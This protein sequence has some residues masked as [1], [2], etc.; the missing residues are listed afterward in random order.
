MKR[1]RLAF[2]ILLLFLV[3]ATIS[4]TA[5]YSPPIQESMTDNTPETSE[6][7]A[8]YV[9]HGNETK[10]YAVNSKL[11][12]VEFKSE[13]FS[14]LMNKVFSSAEEGAVIVLNSGRYPIS[15]TL[16]VLKPLHIYAYG[17]IFEVNA[18]LT[19][20]A[21]QIGDKEYLIFSPH[22]FKGARILNVGKRGEGIGVLLYNSHFGV[23]EDLEVWFFNFAV[24]SKG[25]WDYNVRNCILRINRVGI[26]LDQD[27]EGVNR[28]NH[29]KISG[30]YVGCDIGIH[31]T[32]N[33]QNVIIE[34]VNICDSSQHGAG[35]WIEQAE[36]TIIREC[37]F[38]N[39]PNTD[40]K[41]GGETSQTTA[42]HIEECF[43]YVK[44]TAIKIDKSYYTKV[45]GCMAIN[46]SGDNSTLF[47][48]MTEKAIKL[49]Y[50]HNYIQNLRNNLFFGYDGTNVKI[51]YKKGE[52]YGLSVK[53]S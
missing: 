51:D 46:D 3:I 33:C 53:L 25:S 42:T 31:I 44:K 19:S 6:L 24:Y 1:E 45:E 12:Q 47:I 35:I 50:F 13:N 2:L 36:H 37:Y 43:F 34:T 18:T 17:V 8:D 41:I 14:E 38:E 52:S 23:L 40:I 11:Q 22:S 5:N 20:V 29:F 49:M 7:D 9:I 39:N 28:S 30:G 4:P 27:D 10:F 21:I 48:D 16:K 15:A 32:A 26:K